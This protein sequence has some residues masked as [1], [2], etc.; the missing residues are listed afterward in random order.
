MTDYAVPADHAT[1]SIAEAVIPEPPLE[2]QRIIVDGDDVQEYDDSVIIDGTTYTAANNLTIMK[3]VGSILRPMIYPSAGRAVRIIDKFVTIQDMS[4]QAKSVDTINIGAEFSKIH[5]CLIGAQNLVV[6]SVG[7]SGSSDDAELINCVV[8][9]GPAATGLVSI[10][11]DLSRMK[12]KNNFIHGMGPWSGSERSIFLAG[13]N[14]A[15]IT[16]QNNVLAL[17]QSP[18]I[19]RILD[20]TPTNLVMNGNRY[21]VSRDVERLV[22]IGAV[23]YADLAALQAAGFELDSPHVS[24]F[25][26]FGGGMLQAVRDLGIVDAGVLDD[27]F[28]ESR[29]GTMDIGPRTYEISSIDTTPPVWDTTIGI[30]T[31]ASINNAFMRATWG[32]ATDAAS[33]TSYNVYV[34]EGSAPDSF[35]KASVYYLCNTTLTTLNIFTRAAGAVLGAGKTFYVIVKATDESNNEDANVVSL[36]VTV[37]SSNTFI[38]GVGNTIRSRFKTQV[39]DTVLADLGFSLPTHYDN[40]PFT[41][42]TDDTRWVRHKIEYDDATQVSIAKTSR[43][44]RIFGNMIV[45]IYI[46]L[47]IGDKESSQ[48]A[49]YIASKFRS[50]TDSRVTFRTPQYQLRGRFDKE[51]IVDIRCPFY[52]DTFA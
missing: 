10:T 14:V 6:V 8:G 40:A 48:I 28:A 39:T 4:L 9:Y 34:R 32:V 18:Q 44:H 36:N 41:R 2:A 38:E 7:Y 37:G 35:G 20:A 19:T 27:Y 23:T 13:A 26:H 22:K 43:R 51:W 47:E 15:D 45:S 33:I 52:S 31:L 30:Q 29:V 50:V 11:N 46:R 17:F 12:I 16:L 49:D 24:A 21:F 5:R 42:P 1:I 25:D 3:K